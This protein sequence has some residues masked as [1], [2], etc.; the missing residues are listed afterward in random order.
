MTVFDE[1]LPQLEALSAAY[2]ARALMQIGVSFQPGNRIETSSLADRAGVVPAQRRLLDRLCE[3]LAEVHVLRRGGDGWI[4]ARTPDADDTENRLSSLETRYGKPLQAELAL[5]ARCGPSLGD[6]LIGRKDP[7]AILFPNGSAHL[8]ENLYQVSP[9]ARACNHV[10]ATVVS[11]AIASRPAQQ[12]LRVLE[13]GGGTGSTSSFVL[14][15]LDP[16][17][18]E[19]MF[20]DVSPA[21]TGRAQQK[22]AEY[23]FVRYQTLDIERDPAAQGFSTRFDLVLAANVL[24]ATRDLDETFAHVRQLLAPGGL[25]VMLE[26]VRPQRWID[27]TF[28]LTDGWWRFTDRARR[29]SY[30][31]LDHAGWRSFLTDAGFA[32]I[33][34]I[35]GMAGDSALAIESTIVA[36]GPL[37]AGAA[38][39]HGNDHWL[40]VGD[41]ADGQKLAT[42][43]ERSR[44]RFRIVA[45]TDEQAIAAEISAGSLRGVVHIAS[46]TASAQDVDLEWLAAFEAATCGTALRLVQRLAAAGT[47]IPLT[48][49]T[50]GA[51][52]VSGGTVNPLQAPLWGFGRVVA[53]EHPEL[54]CRLVDLDPSD[55]SFSALAAELLSADTAA[56]G[57]AL[58]DQIAIRGAERLVPRLM[59]HRSQA[60]ASGSPDVYRLEVPKRGSLDGLVLTPA[61]RRSPGPGEVEIRVQATALN[62]RDVMNVLGIYPGDPG[63]LGNECGGT[64]TAVGDGVSHL[65][66]GDQVIGL[67]GGSFASYVTTPATFVV[68][69]PPALDVEDAVTIPIAYVTAY[70]ALHHLGRLTAGDRLLIHA[71]AG[72]VGLAAVHLALRAGAEVFATAGSPEKR[73]YLRSLGVHH[74]M[75]SRTLDFAG[76]IQGKTAGR[77]VTMVLNS[78][79]GEFIARSFDVL[80]AGGRFLEIGKNGWTRQ[81][82]D[83]LGKGLQFHVI[84]WGT[85]AKEDPALIRSMLNEIVGLV[86]RGTLPA[87]PRRAFAMDSVVDAFRFM[88]AGETHREGRRHAYR[89]AVGHRTIRRHVSDHRRLARNRT[90]HGRMA[91]RVRRAPPGPARQ[92]PA[93]ERD[94]GRASAPRRARRPRGSGP[95][96]RLAG[97]RC[98]EGAWACRRN[99]S[100]ASGHHPLCGRAR[101]WGA[102]AAGVASLRDCDG[103]E[104]V[105]CLAP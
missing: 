46:L 66:V 51:Q 36:R 68:P 17:T 91:C 9:A 23:R 74:V 87:L 18:T 27:L 95:G 100:A 5:L 89:R 21:F 76:D 93:I 63:P 35:P 97:R 92:K 12:T 69:K 24:H 75:S 96:R 59:P 79:A 102:R 32:D 8:A 30:P 105:W 6:V 53:L 37:A 29:P 77:G 101:R 7:L 39:A 22:F 88:A 15:H 40:I 20:T 103:A 58:D 4:V 86:A 82:V 50:R 38:A 44:G 52:A 56:Q 26:M 43:L 61:T 54:R 42:E 34:A 98:G 70:F 90:A 85:E 10:L 73:A 28:G 33:N 55:E 94:R 19:Y 57:H 67:A 41:V 72:G 60:A 1:A 71:A 49:V 16:E 78:L 62:F 81:C 84:D 80:A 99:A 64:V 2:V 104:G 45:A 14:P 65:A 48:L 13:I 3:I 31:L 47:G 25:L 83:G 11:E